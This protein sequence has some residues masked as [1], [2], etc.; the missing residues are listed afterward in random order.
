MN[1]LFSR[2]LIPAVALAGFGL[3]ACATAEKAHHAYIMRGSIVAKQ[4]GKVTLCIG[5]KD[6]AQVG[7]TLTVYRIVLASGPSKEPLPHKKESVGMVKIDA[8]VNE[9][10]ATA[11]VVS[12]VA[13][14]NQVVELEP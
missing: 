12:G 9:H 4:A 5:T 10:F 14:V 1:I 8:I 7:Q 13:E 6:G 2:R 11:S 3:F